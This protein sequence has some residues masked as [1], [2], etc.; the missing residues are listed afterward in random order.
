MWGWYCC[1][2]ANRIFYIILNITWHF[3]D[4]IFK[5]ESKRLFCVYWALQLKSSL[6]ILKYCSTIISG[7]YFQLCSCPVSNFSLICSHCHINFIYATS[8][9]V[10]NVLWLYSL[11]SMGL[12][13]IMARAVCIMLMKILWLNLGQQID[14]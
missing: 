3:W 6:A 10:H 5:L 11:V 9:I 4:F 13:S 8:N 12:T 1:Y 2:F 14:R 7:T